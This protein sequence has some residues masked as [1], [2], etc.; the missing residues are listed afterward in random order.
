[1]T[2]QLDGWCPKCAKP[3]SLDPIYRAPSCPQHGIVVDKIYRCHCGHPEE[4]RASNDVP[5]YGH[6]CGPCAEALMSDVQEHLVRVV[7]VST[8]TTGPWKPA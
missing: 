3:L 8:M 7:A 5:Q 6:Y 1:M 2:I 4:F